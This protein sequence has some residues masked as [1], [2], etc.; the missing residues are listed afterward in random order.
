MVFSRFIG[1]PWR[2]LIA[3]SMAL[4]MPW[5][6]VADVKGQAPNFVK[7]WTLRGGY[8][9]TGRALMYPGVQSSEVSTVLVSASDAPIANIPLDATIEA[10]YLFWSGSSPRDAGTRSGAPRA[11]QDQTATFTLPNGSVQQVDALAVDPSGFNTCFLNTALEGQGGFG[12]FYYCRADV[13]S[14]LA[15]LGTGGTGSNGTYMLGD[16]DA[17]AGTLTQSDPQFP[18]AQAKYAVW[19]LLIVW[20]SR[21]A[22]SGHNISLYDSFLQLDE[23]AG[24]S[25][26]DELGVTSYGL[27]G[28]KVDDTRV[29]E[30]TVFAMEGDQQLGVPPQNLITGLGRCD[31]CLDFV[32]VTP[33]GGS[34]QVLSNGDRD[35]GN[36]FTGRYRGGPSIDIN[37]YSLN[38]ILPIGAESVTV[39]VG[40][41]DGN[42]GGGGESFFLGWSLISTDRKFPLIAEGDATIVASYSTAVPGQSLRYT[43]E[44]TNSGSAP[45]TGA[46]LTAAMPE[47]TTY[48]SG[49]T[50]VDGL[51]IADA[52]GIPLVRG[53]NI[54]TV[55]AQGAGRNRR[56]VI[57]EVQVAGDA[58]VVD[59]LEAS[60]LLRSNEL[61]PITI[62]PVSTTLGGVVFSRV[63]KS[64]ALNGSS[65]FEPGASVRYTIEIEG[66]GARDV[67]GIAIEDVIPSELQTTLIVVSGSSS[68][69][70]IPPDGHINLTNLTV[71]LATPLTVNVFATIRS[72]ANLATLFGSVD[73]IH[74]HVVHNLAQASGNCI[75]PV[76][77]NDAT[78]ALT[79]QADMVVTKSVTDD[80]GGLIERGD[81]ITYKVLVRNQGNRNA[82]V[83]LIDPLS[84]ASISY[85]ANS[86]TVAGTNLD[87][88]AYPFGSYDL[89]N[90]IAGD[91]GRESVF[92]VAVAG[93][94][95]DGTVITNTAT[96][97]IQDGSGRTVQASATPLTVI[98]KPN[99]STSSLSVQKTSG[100]SGANYRPGDV[101]TYTFTINNT[102]NVPAS[103]VRILTGVVSPF[104]V[105]TD[106]TTQAPDGSVNLLLGDLGAGASVTRTIVARIVSP[107]NNGT[108]ISLTAAATETTRNYD[109][110]LPTASFTVTS[111]ATV[112]SSLVATPSH[113]PPL[114]GDLID[115]TLTM[116]N[117]GDMAINNVNARIDDQ[118]LN[119][120]LAGNAYLKNWTV[121]QGSGT[122]ENNGVS[123][124]I[125]TLSP[126]LSDTVLRV[127][128][129]VAAVVP[130]NQQIGMI[131]QITG[132]GFT[133]TNVGPVQYTV[134]SQGNVVVIKTVSNVSR[135]GSSFLPGDR[136]R[137]TMTIHASG[138]SPVRDIVVNDPLHSD[139]R[140]ANYDDG[141]AVVGNALQWT[142]S[143]KPALAMLSPG[144]PD[145][146]LFFEA[147]I[148]D[149]ASG[150]SA[151]VNTVTVSST[152]G[153]LVAPVSA[154]ASLLVQRV[155]SP[156]LE[157][158]RQGGQERRPGD[159][160]GFTLRV[161]N[162]GFGD[163][164]NAV[165]SIT[166]PRELSNEVPSVLGGAVLS[167][168]LVGGAQLYRLTWSGGQFAV[169][170]K[171]EVINLAFTAQVAYRIPDGTSLSLVAGLNAD[172]LSSEVASNGATLVIRAS[173]RLVINKVVSNLTSPG[174]GLRPGDRVR[175]DITVTNQGDGV[176]SGLSI[177]DPVDS[178]VL[179]VERVF[180]RTDPMPP[181]PDVDQISLVE[182][183][184][185]D[186]VTGIETLLPPATRG[187][188][189]ASVSVAFEARIVSPLPSGTSIQ[190]RAYVATGASET[191]FS[192]VIIEGVTSEVALTTSS[193]LVTVDG[194]PAIAVD[195]GTTL[196]YAIT[197]RNASIATATA[198]DVVVT[199]AL[200]AAL[201][202]VL[203][204]GSKIQLTGG[205]VVFPENN[206]ST[207]GYTATWS[208]NDFPEL[209]SLL[210]GASA[211]FFL[212]VKLKG[213]I[214]DQTRVN[215]QAL[216]TAVQAPSGAVT[217]GDLTN[218]TPGDK[219][220]IIARSQPNLRLF[221]LSV[222]DPTNGSRVAQ[223]IP[224]QRLRILFQVENTGTERIRSVQVV[225]AGLSDALENIT[226]T[227]GTFNSSSRTLQWLFDSISPRDGV[228]TFSAD[229]QVKAV[230][231]AGDVSMQAIMQAANIA[232][233]LSDDPIL[234]GVSDP[235]HFTIVSQAKFASI[236]L[237]IVNNPAQVAPLENLTYQIPLLNSGTAEAQNTVVTLT[238]WPDTLEFVSAGRGGVYDANGKRVQWILGTVAARAPP[239]V[240][241]VN[242]RVKRVVSNGTI[243]ALQGHITADGVTEDLT[244][245]PTEGV[246]FPTRVTVTAHPD[247]SGARLEVADL[248][249]PVPGLV[250]PGHHLQYTLRIANHGSGSATGVVVTFPVP[251]G[252]VVD[253]NTLPAGMIVNGSNLVYT[254]GILEPPNELGVIAEHVALFNAVITPDALRGRIISMQGNVAFTEGVPFKTDG[255][256]IQ[257]GQQT[258][259]ILVAYPV[260]SLVHTVN[261]NNG[262]VIAPG[263]TLAFALTVSNQG[264]F[265]A[266][267]TTLRVPIDPLL[268]IAA[269][270]P[271]DTYRIESG[272]VIF[273]VGALL[274]NASENRVYNAQI[275]IAAKHRQVI[276]SQAT[277]TATGA[278]DVLSDWPD[279]PGLVDPITL[280]VISLPNLS[281][282]H[283]SLERANTPYAQV[284]DLIKYTITLSNTGTGEAPALIIADALPESL[285]FDHSVPASTLVD[286]EVRW[287][288]GDFQ[289][290]DHATLTV[291]ATVAPTKTRRFRVSNQAVARTPVLLPAHVTSNDVTFDVINEAVFQTSTLVITDING[292]TVQPGD[293]L[294]VE[295]V[296]INTGTEKSTGS[297]MQVPL[298]ALLQYVP[299]STTVNGVA[300]TQEQGFPAEYAL[301]IR[302]LGSVTPGEIPVSTGNNADWAHAAFDVRVRAGAPIGAQLSLQ[303]IAASDNG[304]T[305]GS[306]DPNTTSVLGDATWVMV[307]SHTQI[308]FSMR[309]EVIEIA[310]TNNMA[311]VGETIRYS[312]VL[313][314]AG[315]F[316]VG[317]IDFE[318]MLPGNV[319][320]TEG[321]LVLDGT[322]IPD[323]ITDQSIHTRID[324]VDP[325]TVHTLTFDVKPTGGTQVSNQA[326]AYVTSGASVSEWIS[327]GD[328]LTEG[329]QATVTPL[330]S[331]SGLVVHLGGVDVNGGEVVAGDTLRL[332]VEVEN[333]GNV[334]LSDISIALLLPEGT[335]GLGGILGS[336]I[337]P[338]IGTSTW[339]IPRMEA[340]SWVR[341]G[342]DV[343]IN[344]NIAKDTSLAFSATA[345]NSDKVSRSETVSWKVGG[346]TGLS[347]VIGQAYIE[348]GAHT[349]YQ[350]GEDSILPKL[351]LRAVSTAEALSVSRGVDDPQKSNAVSGDEQGRFHFNS[352][353]PGRYV[354]EALNTHGAVLQRGAAFQVAA[355]Q[356]TIIDLAMTPTGQV[357]TIQDAHRVPVAGARVWLIDANTNLPAD[358][359]LL[360]EGQ[361]GQTT[362]A[363]GWYAFDILA[364]QI[365][366]SRDFQ[367]RI[368]PGSGILFFPSLTVQS[369]QDS[370]QLAG[371]NIVRA[372]DLYYLNLH[373][374]TGA[375]TLLCNDIPLDHASSRIRVEKIAQPLQASIG[376]IV[377]YTIQI[378]NNGDEPISVNQ[379]GTGGI[380]LFDEFPDGIRFVADSAVY[381][382]YAEQG[383][384]ASGTLPVVDQAVRST[385][386][387]ALSLP[388][389]GHIEVRYR[390]VVGLRSIGAQKNVAYV[391]N[392]NTRVSNI[393]H[394]TVDVRP[395]PVFE[396]G[397]IIGQVTCTDGRGIAGAHIAMDTGFIVDTDAKGRYHIQGQNPG[398]HAVKLDL[399]S[400]LPSMTPVSD[401]LREVHMTRGLLSKIDF[402]VAC[403]DVA[404]KPDRVVVGAELAPPVVVAP[405]G[406]VREPPLPSPVPVKSEPAIKGTKYAVAIK[407]DKILVNGKIRKLSKID[408]VV[409]QKD[410][411][412]DENN[413]VALIDPAIPIEWHLESD[414]L[415]PDSLWELA[416][417]NKEAKRVWYT[418]GLGIPPKVLPWDPRAN[419]IVGN[420]FYA[421][422]VSARDKNGN[423]YESAWKFLDTRKHQMGPNRVYREEWY[424]DLFSKD[425]KISPLLRVHLQALLCQMR[426]ALT[427][428]DGLEFHVHREDEVNAA[429][430][431]ALDAKAL[432][433]AALELGFPETHIDVRPYGKRRP[434]RLGEGKAAIRRNRR[435]VVWN[436]PTVDIDDPSASPKYAA[437]KRIDTVNTDKRDV[438]LGD[439]QATT[440]DLRNENGVRYVE[441]LQ[442]S[443]HT[444][445]AKKL[446]IP[447]Q[448][449]PFGSE[450]LWLTNAEKF[451]EAPVVVTKEESSKEEKKPEKKAEEVVV[452]VA[453]PVVVPVASY[454]GDSTVTLPQEGAVLRGE[455]VTVFGK[456][457]EN[458]TVTVAGQDVATLSDGSFSKTLVLK[459]G[460]QRIDVAIADASGSR[461]EFSRNVKVPDHE[462]FGVGLATATFGKGKA[463]DGQ[464]EDSHV[465]LGDYYFDGQMRAYVTGRSSVKSWWKKS[466]WETARG[467]LFLDTSFVENAVFQQYLLDIDK[468]NPVYGD[469]TEPTIDTFTRRKGYLRLELDGSKIIVGN[470]AGDLNG[471]ELFRYRRSLWG[472][473]LNAKHD[474]GKTGVS[475]LEVIAGDSPSGTGT[476]SIVFQ[477]T[478]GSMYQLQDRGVEE[479]SEQINLVVR[480]S[481]HGGIVT[482][483][484]QRRDIDYRIDYASGRLFFMKPIL[485]TVPDSFDL[486]LNP[487]QNRNG[488]RMFVESTYRY[489]T[490]LAGNSSASYGF[491]AG[492][493]MQQGNVHVGGGF[494]HQAA[495]ADGAG[496]FKLAAG[497]VRYKVHKA[498]NVVFEGAFSQHQDAALMLSTDGGLTF[499]AVGKDLQRVVSDT[500]GY[501]IQGRVEGDLS[502]F[503]KPKK[504]SPGL[505][506]YLR[507]IIT[508]R[509]QTD[510][511]FASSASMQ[512]GQS[513]GGLEVVGGPNAKHQLRLRHDAVFTAVYGQA[514]ERSLL[515][516]EVMQ[517]GYTYKQ[518]KWQV[519]AES[520]YT[521]RGLSGVND[522]A[523]VMRVFGTMRLFS[524]LDATLSQEANVGGNNSLFKNDIDRMQTTVGLDYKM[525]K[526]LSLNVR[527]SIRWNGDNSTQLG[528]NTD[529][530]HGLRM[531]VSERMNMGQSLTTNFSTVVGAESTAIKGSRSYAEYQ[532]DNTVS[533][534]RGRAV[535]GMDN[536]WDIGRGISL[537]L[538]YERQQLT[539]DGHATGLPALTPTSAKTQ[540]LGAGALAMDRQFMA[541]SY[542][543]SAVFPTGMAS[544]DAFTVGLQYALKKKLTASA[545]VEI[546]Y[547]KAGANTGGLHD[548]LVVFGSTA[549][550]Y[551]FRDDFVMLARV[552]G[553]TV[554]DDTSGLTEGEFMDITLGAAL[555][556]EHGRYGALLKWTRRYEKQRL[557]GDANNLQTTTKDVMSFEPFSELVWGFQATGKVALKMQD[558]IDSITPGTKATTLLALLRLNYH[559]TKMFDAAVEYRWLWSDLAGQTDQG[560]LVEFAWIPVKYASVGIGY[561]WAH[562]SDDLLANPLQNTHGFFLRMTGRF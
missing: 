81:G 132:T 414:G 509:H 237:T 101:V 182:W 403:T 144:D 521:M 246:D 263:D 256:L 315:D 401:I 450:P 56:V 10:A 528:I 155:A 186:P 119:G 303:A 233:T 112:V 302:G 15:G 485:L 535:F 537:L 346:V 167:Q 335:Q 292:G 138:N 16:V 474:F 429:R 151:L 497:D 174:A 461:A 241:E 201:E 498:F 153:D 407:A 553:A 312:L 316:A 152:S 125:G 426:S 50:T 310:P 225:L 405:V 479:G 472:L 473:D 546:R 304:S 164:Q 266:N 336:D 145:I 210:P 21:S 539:G 177:Q 109:A 507:Y 398:R 466:P 475:G 276:T 517:L 430:D 427:R 195:V 499:A 324:H 460:D 306:D 70:A 95:A 159:A 219:T 291:W 406:A 128:V 222:V 89:G 234:F 248:D 199:D 9:S 471:G 337:S 168:V 289:P 423:I 267:T 34:Y 232:E 467:V 421:Y 530:G 129:Q 520:A 192:N 290:G 458:S 432:R 13:T 249:S 154:N 428:G 262:G 437:W 529:L 375:G 436:R 99:L 84:S 25:G 37:T 279:L 490:Q 11:W 500:S 449:D 392:D 163:A 214:D 510:G 504:E 76:A 495:S 431:A 281:D 538:T 476:R 58:C 518:E 511:F 39:R 552:R 348:S 2:V 543:S 338:S 60:A 321:T 62:G 206:A 90:I 373:V 404:S 212:P 555:R 253:A 78:F 45:L 361:Q 108:L 184:W 105:I 98:A 96:A 40:S 536:K 354:L 488:Q 353:A 326:H 93:N 309:A 223:A 283:K 86:A 356:T 357:Y 409:E 14:L 422:R 390:G 441:L 351:S 137:Y 532:L 379:V 457:P 32:G 341:L 1:A 307:G 519:G 541:S 191:T 343:R 8:S 452:P 525:T 23:N 325:H 438:V 251:S 169:L 265:V 139:L 44:F 106:G 415:A 288:L 391:E 559:L 66:D 365:T 447:M 334:L 411:L 420:T 496:A 560:A 224:G 143:R 133:T 28:F 465:K 282:L 18:Y 17:D 352:L 4:L 280:T 434:L 274:P 160:V 205:P 183:E 295:V 544:R 228:K 285:I 522:H 261:D 526:N 362:D 243:I 278:D 127:R 389:R 238:N 79:Y 523:G 371:G 257:N 305:I 231:N 247:I 548:R 134:S 533:A 213:P 556:P 176:A 227:T 197:V 435:V 347:A 388:G 121:L 270:G 59:H 287:S 124:V 487:M 115:I 215:N 366:T 27:S 175:Y 395:D 481:I 204:L 284:G 116:R 313:E 198:T 300:I 107:M 6:A 239:D 75:A 363:S 53:I 376:E 470:V 298:P 46:V 38:S 209:K 236:P 505:D 293:M 468:Y 378:I 349:G 297:S 135:S 469:A 170:A 229:V 311:D 264:N 328:P 146:S 269:P 540:A 179:I 478:G 165:V 381:R 42:S 299:G 433:K 92:R 330:S 386:F 561:N 377:N 136:I 83:R 516:Q 322:S 501:A 80:N 193:K 451:N 94:T 333:K 402:V 258:T 114:P 562:F 446:N 97:L 245:S 185:S 51:G 218:N 384:V 506:P 319:T 445:D 370:A 396:Q 480:D 29:S 61:D 196:V 171:D 484:P 382:T 399:N 360:R 73:A 103:G 400:L 549:A 48:V 359:S 147:T 31:T 188:S 339:L 320:Y 456:A 162:P 12:G 550:D 52:G 329:V 482:S 374:D 554:R 369:Y 259:D 118:L 286:N 91:A 113:T 513:R 277:G 235:T 87:S 158:T 275:L 442:G 67:R 244:D 156:V 157:L 26:S 418:Q 33:P 443:K 439:K 531:Y 459:P 301:S 221:S 47:H 491:Y 111:S 350:A 189:F 534:Q 494:V 355:G 254:L 454:V 440:I 166:L 514:A 367:I 190:N 20:K 141:S 385:R 268:T 5:A 260:L 54:G 65:R 502:D 464:T 394:A 226:T 148:K 492:H 230:V 82:T 180:N 542:V 547:D 3:F 512:Q 161:T 271:L 36:A 503:V 425:H 242:A 486:A 43:I 323:A 35:P 412:H 120:T 69:P 102:G 317:P 131:G 308:A 455:R 417:Y 208:F 408:V 140:D 100:S 296:V 252:L 397:T 318:D 181:V 41:G 551:R 202:P 413:T 207:I 368:E 172:G 462:W 364:D 393:A 194:Q 527:E 557:D 68:F 240:L 331:G 383:L 220:S 250:R 55:P 477:A 483:I 545:Q 178:R 122:V 71:P 515:H 126:S 448:G 88:S 216:I 294:H 142:S 358:A 49:S 85:I 508:G 410:A 332:F 344:A 345:G 211:T 387:G 217:D 149:D 314:N 203:P 255:D 22:T 24:F 104:L 173:A 77:T 200:S 272:F 416:V 444:F 110:T 372:T 463:L 424:G 342:F 19:S 273:D 117:T 74:G 123:F 64:V 524:K 130:R 419:S 558:V 63:E 7:S 30:L 327:D 493:D 72:E 150:A 187:G 57:F 453:A 340:T 380:A 489:N